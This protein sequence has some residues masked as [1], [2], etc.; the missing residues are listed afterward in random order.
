MKKLSIIFLAAFSLFA[1]TSCNDFLDMKPTNSTDTKGSITTVVDAQ[2]AE[3]GLVRAML[4]SSLYGRNMFLYG[5]AKGGD[6]TVVSNGRG[7]DGLYTFSH[8]AN[9]G[10][11]SGFWSTGFSC[12]AQ[13][14]NVLANIDLIE[15]AGTLEDFSDIKAHM[16]SYR[17]MIYYD[18]VRIYGKD[19]SDGNPATNLGVPLV[20]TSLES[21]DQ[22]ARATVADI[23]KQIVSDLTTAEAMFEDKDVQKGYMNYWANIALQARVAMSMQQYSSAL[24]LCEKIMTDSGRDLYSNE[25]WADSW[26]TSFGSEYILEFFVNEKEADLGSSS[27]GMTLCREEDYDGDASGYFVAS[28]YWLD[29]M[30]EDS[31]DVRWGVMDYDELS[32]SYDEDATLTEDRYGSCYKYLGGLEMKGDKGAASGTAVNIKLIRLSEIYLIAAEAAYRTNAKGKAVIYLNAIR[33]RAPDLTPAT[34]ATIS[35]DMILDEKSKEFFGEGLRYF[36]MIRCN[37]TIK[38]N[39]IIKGGEGELPHPYRDSE[40]NRSFFRCILPISVDEMI[41]N[42]NLVQNDGYGK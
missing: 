17:A 10:S 40:I 36:D 23:Y 41:V 9:S 5:D 13:I 34:E 16:L 4:S 32:P 14:N 21:T 11:Y 33:K 2:V 15:K 29:R 25:K 28:D 1:F 20:T 18:L 38:F 6:L 31:K 3:N 27:L 37:K 42:S 35:I 19:Y 30:R 22:P 8:T 7:Y 24:S 26:A 39:D 12:I